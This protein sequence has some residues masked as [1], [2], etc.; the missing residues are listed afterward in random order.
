[1][2]RYKHAM[3][4]WLI[5]LASGIGFQH[6]FSSGVMVEWQPNS[7]NVSGYRIYYGKLSRFYRYA[8]DVGNTTE[9]NIPTMPDS[10]LYYFSVT[11]YDYNDIESIYSE[12]VSFH[13]PWDDSMEP[14]EITGPSDETDSGPELP[15]SSENQDTEQS[16]T[17]NPPSTDETTSDDDQ[18]T[19]N[20]DDEEIWERPYMF[21]IL[22]NYPNPM[23]PVTHIPYYLNSPATV[24]IKIYDSIGRHVKTLKETPM[25]P[26]QYEITWDGTNDYGNAVASGIYICFMQVGQ[27]STSQKMHLIR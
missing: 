7:D 11:A 19:Q 10:G 26:G 1:M 13:V 17:N 22:P 20:P 9:Y 6:L 18:E 21:D 2:I 23:N 3:R 15:P 14:P 8:I 5:L 25:E 24:R 16:D 12:E 27:Y 4:I